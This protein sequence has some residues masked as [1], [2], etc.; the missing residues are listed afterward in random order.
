M[1]HWLITQQQPKFKQIFNQQPIVPYK[2]EK[3]LKD[4]LVRTKRPS[5]KQ[6]S[7]NQWNVKLQPEGNLHMISL[8]HP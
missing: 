5:I 7:Q 8:N 1:K 3:S 2:K 4:I 6:E